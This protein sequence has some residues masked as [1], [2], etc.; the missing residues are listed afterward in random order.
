MQVSKR[1]LAS[2]DGLE[3]LWMELDKWDVNNSQSI[4][5]DGKYSK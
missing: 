4:D 1:Y 2:Q 3:S 5:F